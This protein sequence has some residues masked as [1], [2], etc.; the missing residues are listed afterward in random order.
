MVATGLPAV[1]VDTNVV[2][3]EVIE[4]PLTVEFEP[5]LA[6]H[7]GLVSFQTVAEL[8]LIA[9]RRSWGPRLRQ[10]LEDRLGLLAR[11]GASEE[12]TER[13]AALMFEQMRVGSRIETA[14][15][16]IAATA[17]VY[18]CPILTNDRKDFERV[19]GLRLL[20]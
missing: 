16:W 1:V 20:P 18:G 2:I 5:F 13:W 15:A 8:R 7:V 12:I 10:R 11:A 4:H 17:L 3:Y 14:D 9:L 6:S 19:A